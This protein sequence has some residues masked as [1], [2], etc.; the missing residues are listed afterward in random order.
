LRRGEQDLAFFGFLVIETPG[1]ARVNPGR[2]GIELALE[3]T[4]NPLKPF[5]SG[6][7]SN[8]CTGKDLNTDELLNQANNSQH[9]PAIP[10]GFQHR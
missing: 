5:G 7:F 4:Q 10:S 6:Y 2:V 8:C 3:R 1:K 9:S